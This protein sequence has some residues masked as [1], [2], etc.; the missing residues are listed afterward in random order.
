MEEEESTLNGVL[1]AMTIILAVLKIFGVLNIPFWGIFVP[2]LAK[3]TID[4][5]AILIFAIL[6]LSG[7]KDAKDSWEKIKELSTQ[8]WEAVKDSRKNDANGE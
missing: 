8:Y 3:F 2:F 7:N 5:A 6:V 4:L 1:W